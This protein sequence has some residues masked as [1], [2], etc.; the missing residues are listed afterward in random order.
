MLTEK[1]LKRISKNTKKGSE[2]N[3]KDYYHIGKRILKKNEK[4]DIHKEQ[5]VSAQRT[6]RFYSVKRENWK[7][8]S[9]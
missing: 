8:P 7:G 6:Y 1:L 2:R 3:K 4:I 9:P 5:L